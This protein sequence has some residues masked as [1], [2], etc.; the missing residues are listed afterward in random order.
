M[1]DAGQGVSQRKDTC[2]ASRSRQE[3]DQ[4]GRS[5]GRAVGSAADRASRDS[6]RVLARVMRSR[7]SAVLPVGMESNCEMQTMP[8]EGDATKRALTWAHNVGDCDHHGAGL[9]SCT[10][11]INQTCLVPH[12]LSLPLVIARAEH[13]LLLCRT[14]YV[15]GCQHFDSRW[16]S[17][18]A[19]LDCTALFT[20]TRSL[21]SN[22]T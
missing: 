15:L 4:V 14:G 20:V 22:H 8:D 12:N 17:D 5:R 10:A 19:L 18:T 1:G 9:H 3:N 16:L 7:G 2:Y 13:P 21:L 6:S 11:W